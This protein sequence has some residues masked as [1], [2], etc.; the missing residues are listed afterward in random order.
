M[1]D[2]DIKIKANLIQK[3][4]SNNIYN[5]K[6]LINM[7]YEQGKKLKLTQGEDEMLTKLCKHLAEKGKSE[8]EFFTK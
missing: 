1:L 3:L 8:L 2:K 7:T 4:R 6:Q 5:E